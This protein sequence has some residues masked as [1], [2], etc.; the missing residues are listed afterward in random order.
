MVTLAFH[1][2]NVGYKQMHI[3]VNTSLDHFM[4]TPWPF[5]IKMYKQTNIITS[6]LHEE[7]KCQPLAA[8]RRVSMMMKARVSIKYASLYC[9][10][11]MY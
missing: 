9:L 11:L 1:Y 4:K 3:I 5:T 2:Q 7:I 8:T 6:R 10:L